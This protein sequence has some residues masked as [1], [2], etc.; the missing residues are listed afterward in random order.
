ME[1]VLIRHA[2]VSIT[3]EVPP[4]EWPLAEA[5]AEAASAL[6]QLPAVR[7]VTLFAHSPAVKARATA[8]ALAQHR[9]LLEI[10][11]LAE[12]DRSAA[13]WVGDQ[14]A[15]VALVHEIFAHPE[16]S[17]RG[18][19]PA[20]AA[21]AR[22]SSAI[23]ALVHDHPEQRIAV[24]SHGIVLSLYL[25]HLRGTAQADVEEWQRIA[26]P[27]VAVVDLIER[28]VVSPWRSLLGM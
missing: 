27:D 20:S 3:P 5:G 8:Q 23:S 26:L 9:P 13:G 4:S 25:A 24:V 19:E 7:R 10:P 14:Q 17:I 6:A 15:Y 16:R 2:A 21:Q 28:T 18:C 12:L 11:G 1:L 22:I